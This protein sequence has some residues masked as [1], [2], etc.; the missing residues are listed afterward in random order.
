MVPK[1]NH[2]PGARAEG[3]RPWGGS[4]HP[5]PFPRP[6]PPPT[7]LHAGIGCGR[8]CE[9]RPEPAGPGLVAS[10]SGPA[11]STARPELPVVL[12]GRSPRTLLAAGVSHPAP[13]VLPGGTCSGR[14]WG[15]PSPQT[16]PRALQLLPS[17]P[18]VS[19][20]VP[21]TSDG[22]PGCASEAVGFVAAWLGVRDQ[23]GMGGGQDPPRLRLSRS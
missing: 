14:C 21:V 15:V 3:P 12:A 10:G 2:T 4:C 16:W 5:P 18:R 8:A 7:F 1:T 6:R 19:L 13:L 9:R 11:P 22:G 20:P 17:P 23:A